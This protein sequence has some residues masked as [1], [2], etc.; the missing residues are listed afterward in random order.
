MPGEATAHDSPG[1]IQQR[2]IALNR[3]R[4]LREALTWAEIDSV[5]LPWWDLV[6][7]RPG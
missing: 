4:R 5:L 6:P 3:A 1:R 2:A 7:H